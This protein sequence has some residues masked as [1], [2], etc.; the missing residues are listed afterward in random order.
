MTNNPDSASQATSQ[1]TSQGNPPGPADPQLAKEPSLGPACLV[2]AILLL[3]GF[4]AV[5]GF[6]SWFVFSDQYPLAE[7]GISQQL[8]P[9]VETSQ[10]AEADKR[11]I[12]RQ[13][14]ALLP[15][16]QARE[17]DQQQ[18][19]RLHYC[20]QDN[21]VLLWGGVQSILIQARNSSELSQT[22]KETIERLNQRLLR[23]A[24]DRQLGR[25]DL[26]FTLQNV[27]KVRED[28][29]SIEVKPELTPAQMRDFMTRA[30]QLLAKYDVPNTPYEKTPAEAFEILIDKALNPPEE[31]TP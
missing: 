10:L 16:L 25:R 13:L 22:E 1:G 31:P 4:L 19:T 20:L 21:P 8:I 27:S 11:S 17:L 30:E 12:I 29:A 9:W 2:V 28:G 5:G 26:E 24:T 14:Q 15:R 23:M 18:L 3:A 6:L 7:R